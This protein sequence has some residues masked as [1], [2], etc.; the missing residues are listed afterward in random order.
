[1][2]KNCIILLFCLI[3]T[4]PS[5]GQNDA[6]KRFHELEDS[7]NLQEVHKA[8]NQVVIAENKNEIK[9]LS[10]EKDNL[11]QYAQ[12][13]EK[14]RAYQLLNDGLEY[15]LTHPYDSVRIAELIDNANTISLTREQ[16]DEINERTKLLKSYKEKHEQM[17]DIV[18]AMSET[19]KNNTK[20]QSIW[21]D[22]N[23]KKYQQRLRDAI[24]NELGKRQNDINQIKTIPY[25]NTML[26]T[27]DNENVNPFT[28]FDSLKKV[29]GI[30]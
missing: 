23:N 11:A 30:K 3:C 26:A 21:N 25:F 8:R 22:Q 24:H 13:Y 27:F 7:I 1:M 28:Q 5:F 17:R 15:A 10:E 29:F 9:F 19:F 6:V 20:I 4:V 12:N 18:K 16:K 14:E 2:K